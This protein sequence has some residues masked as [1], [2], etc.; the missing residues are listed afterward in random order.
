MLLWSSLP[1]IYKRDEAKRQAVLSAQNPWPDCVLWHL[2]LDGAG[3]GQKVVKGKLWKAH[4]LVWTEANGPIPQ[5]RQI[6]HRCDT[7][8]CVNLGHLYLGTQ[9]DNV[10]DM[11]DRGTKRTPWVR[12]T[13]C[14]AGHLYADTEVIRPNGTRYCRVCHRASKLA[15]YHRRKGKGHHDHPLSGYPG[16]YG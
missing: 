12:K 6:N 2:S 5:G 15:S 4:R 14:P 3:Y 10:Q 8:A 11:V 9:K 13:H 1:R 7:P 16:P